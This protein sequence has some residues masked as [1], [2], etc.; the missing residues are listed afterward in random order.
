MGYKVPD[1]LR[2]SESSVSAEMKPKK[3]TEFE[4]LRFKLY[5]DVTV[6]DKLMIFAGQACEAFTAY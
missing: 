4:A 5:L 6:L 2:A 3:K 1:S